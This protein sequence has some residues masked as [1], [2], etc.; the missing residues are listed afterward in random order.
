MTYLVAICL[1]ARLASGMLVP[2]ARL[3][4][5][6]RVVQAELLAYGSEWAGAR[7]GWS[8][9]VGGGARWERRWVH[10]DEW[11]QAADGSWSLWCSESEDGGESMLVRVEGHGATARYE[12]LAQPCLPD[13]FGFLLTNDD[14]DGVDMFTHGA[15]TARVGWII[16]RLAYVEIAG[17]ARRRVLA[18]E[19]YMALPTLLRCP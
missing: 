1:F 18:R 2:P 15:G 13:S 12:V 5:A 10:W 17:D 9:D 8:A 7:A 16:H 11:S 3:E 14:V 4:A 6:C 19:L